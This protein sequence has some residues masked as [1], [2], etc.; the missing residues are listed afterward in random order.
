V[1]F[2]VQFP[3]IASNIHFSIPSDIFFFDLIIV[4]GLMYVTNLLDGIITPE[5]F[6]PRVAAILKSALWLGYWAVSGCVMT[7]LWVIGHECG[8]GGFSAFPIINSVV[9]FLVHS[10]LLVPFFSWKISHRRHH[11]N[12]GNLEYDEVF[13]PH[14]RDVDFQVHH[15]D[16]GGLFTNLKGT[17]TR[18]FNIVIMMLLGWPLYLTLN[19]TGHESYPKGT[20]V[21]HFIPTS[22]IFAEK[23]RVLVLLSD[24]GI[25]GVSLILYRIASIYSFLWLVKIYLIPLLVVNFFLVL[26]TFLQHTDYDLPHYTAK[27]WD[28]LRG[29]LATI[30]RDFGILNG[31]FHHI[32]D[33]HVVHHLFSGMPFYHAKEAT[34]AVKP[35]LKDYYRFDRTHWLHA[36]WINF[37]CNFVQPDPD[38]GEKRAGILWFRRPL[39][40]NK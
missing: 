4:L 36:L 26:I 17:I 32:T 7:G 13:V 1:I 9:G 12:T 31:V 16:D 34:K 20:W 3:L 2:V 15:D 18:L 10:F 23:E 28:W 5:D 8:H 35:L 14:V 33:T 11:S 40:H 27:E 24:I 39:S 30:D 38:A 21:N 25:V 37:E 6:G 29:A 22:P 19:V